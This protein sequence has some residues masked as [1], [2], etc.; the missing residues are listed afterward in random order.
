MLH[1]MEREVLCFLEMS[2]LLAFAKEHILRGNLP[3]I[4]LSLKN[5]LYTTLLT[6]PHGNRVFNAFC[7]KSCFAF[8]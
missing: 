6:T 7:K 2:L 5:N 1:S 4:S 3:F 8:D